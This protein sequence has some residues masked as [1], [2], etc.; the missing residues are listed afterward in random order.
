M[1]LEITTF[2]VLSDEL[3]KAMNI[4]VVV[5][6]ISAEMVKTAFYKKVGFKVSVR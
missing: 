3:S 1:E 5:Y 6:L 2:F 4:H